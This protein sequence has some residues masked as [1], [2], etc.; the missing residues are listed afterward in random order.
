MH[1]MHSFLCTACCECHSGAASG[2]NLHVRCDHDF[3]APNYYCFL[4]S[5]QFHAVTATLTLTLLHRKFA[6]GPILSRRW[7]KHGMAAF[8]SYVFPM[9]FAL[10]C[11]VLTDHNNVQLSTG[12]S[13]LQEMWP[14]AHQH[15]WKSSQLICSSLSQAC[16]SASPTSP[17][18][19]P[20]LPTWS[21]GAGWSPATLPLPLPLLRRAVTVKV[22]QL[23][24]SCCVC[25]SCC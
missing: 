2:A 5:I 24:C 16:M 19:I 18:P 7:S 8:V 20:P 6:Y 11:P 22:H 21:C 25:L 14:H 4:F 23:C 3:A 17:L 13:P 1:C 10:C 12:M 15:Q 9:R